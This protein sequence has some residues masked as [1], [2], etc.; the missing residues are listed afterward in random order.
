M[1]LNSFYKAAHAWL[2]EHDWFDIGARVFAGIAIVGG[3]FLLSK[4]L[5]AGLGRLRRRADAAAPVIYIVEQLGTYLC[6]LVGV[7]VAASVL[8]LNLSSLAIFGGALG[9]GVGL[10]LQGIVKEFVSGLVLMF[11]PTIQVGDF[12]EVADGIHGEV[13]QIGPR[14]TRIRTNDELNVIIPNSSLMQGRVINW[15][16]NDASR[17]IH[18]PFS[19]AEESDIAQVRDVVLTAAKALP[20]TLPDDDVHKTQVWLTNFGATGLDF[21][22]VVWPTLDSSRHPRTMH[23]AYTW[24][25]YECLQAAGIE[26]ADPRMDVRLREPHPDRADRESPQRAPPAIERQASA[27]NDAAAAMFDDAD[28]NQRRRA[29]PPRRREPR[30][31]GDSN[32]N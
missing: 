16:Y 4:L 26:N 20:F 29:E 31:D 2:V 22:L 32:G 17:R 15:T 25:V 27:P 8:G 9:V 7:L 23:A 10:G 21:D 18:V 30:S 13:V 12:V 1:D 11:D 24:A 5:R 6:I 3:A 28:R 19:V 14:A